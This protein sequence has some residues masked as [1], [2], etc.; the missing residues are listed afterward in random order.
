MD[1]E[2]KHMVAKSGLWILLVAGL[3]LPEVARAQERPT[4]IRAT[5]LIDGKG[6]GTRNVR[7][8]VQGTRITRIGRT[9]PAAQGTTDDLEGM[10]VMPG[11]IDTPVSIDAHFDPT[12]KSHDG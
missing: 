12:A 8:V 5:T 9:A 7:I 2:D 3:I 4:V 6:G 1:S 11:W 10:N